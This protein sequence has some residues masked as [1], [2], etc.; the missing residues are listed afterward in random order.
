MGVKRSK[1]PKIALPCL[2]HDPRKQ[3]CTC[4]RP[5]QTE[6]KL[7]ERIANEEGLRKLGYDLHGKRI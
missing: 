1:E 3:Q 7:A 4:I 6:A 5:V 2:F